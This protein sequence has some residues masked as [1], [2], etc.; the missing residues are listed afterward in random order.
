[1]LLVILATDNL[2][3]LIAVWVL[4]FTTANC[5]YRQPSTHMH[6]PA[7]DVDWSFIT[8]GFHKQKESCQGLQQLLS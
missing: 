2:I 6:S 1:M 3:S 5:D 4:T 7:Q 8:V